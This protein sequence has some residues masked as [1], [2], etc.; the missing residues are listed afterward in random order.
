MGER[1]DPGQREGHPGFVG[2]ALRNPATWRLALL[3]TAVFGVPLTIGAWFVHY[4]T[5]EGTLAPGLAGGLAFALFGASAL[6]RRIGGAGGSWGLTPAPGG[7]L[8]P[9]RDRRSGSHRP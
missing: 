8:P 9:A 2:A 6:M 1:D 5:V 7:G 3:F 4:V